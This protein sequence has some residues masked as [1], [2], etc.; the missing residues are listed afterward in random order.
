MRACYGV[1]K[2]LDSASQVCYS[3]SSGNDT[4]TDPYSPSQDILSTILFY[5]STALHSLHFPHYALPLESLPR[6]RFHS[7]PRAP[8]HS[9]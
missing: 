9:S 4:V 6:G 3:D 8:R 7:S 2:P 1:L 5:N